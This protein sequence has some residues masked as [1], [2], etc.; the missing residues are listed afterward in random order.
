M[1]EIDAPE[2]TRHAKPGQFV[3]L[4]C[5]EAGERLPFTLANIDRENGTISI[6]FQVVGASTFR[7]NQ[8]MP[9]DS[10]VDLVGPLGN[11]SELE[12]LDKVV[13]IGGGLGCAILY[14]LVKELVESKKTVDTIIGF[15]TQEYVFM[16]KEFSDISN[17]FQLVTEDGSAGA[18]G[19]VTDVLAKWL[20][21]KEP[22]DVVYAIGPLPM[23][24]AVANLTRPLK[25]KT[26]VSMNPIMVDGTGMCGGCRLKVGGKIK[27]AC[28]DGPEFDGH[29]VDFDEVI[30]RNKMY[31]DMEKK[32]YDHVCRLKRN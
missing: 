23:M 1:I 31:A 12:G 20:D 19:L 13:M 14:P 30:T 3:M 27:F 17:R 5:E 26:I 8:L 21:P 7:L 6:I 24:K 25:I 11:P 2:V 4:R 29:E 9:G 16:D 18:K 10:L 15:R 32:Q 28:V 22:I